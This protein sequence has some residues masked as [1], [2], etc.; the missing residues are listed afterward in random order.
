MLILAR[1]W[2]G[3]LSQRSPAGRLR[4]AP[5]MLK[6]FGGVSSAPDQTTP[7][8][9]DQRNPFEFFSPSSR[10]GSVANA[11]PAAGSSG[12]SSGTVTATPSGS[13]TPAQRQSVST[14]GLGSP[15]SATAPAGSA[16]AAGAGGAGG[17]AL[18]PPPPTTPGSPLPGK[19]AFTA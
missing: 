4:S 13:A 1:P 7:K 18:D 10:K 14:P 2:S 9:S 8:A 19:P 12:P 6:F 17:V 5:E 3:G 11:H 15:S 16:Q